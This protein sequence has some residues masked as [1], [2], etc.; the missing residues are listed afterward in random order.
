[1]LES[2]NRL[3]TIRESGTTKPP[4]CRIVAILSNVT[5]PN[6]L[7]LVPRLCPEPPTTVFLFCCLGPLLTN[8]LFS[9][10][11]TFSQTMFLSCPFFDEFLTHLLFYLGLLP[12]N[13]SFSPPPSHPVG[14]REAPLFPRTPLSIAFFACLCFFPRFS[15]PML[16]F[17]RYFPKSF[18]S[19]QFTTVSL[20]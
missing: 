16:P 5:R 3:V 17:L 10:I 2:V 9:F 1:M 20:P 18:M 13:E 8:V 12:G 19:P 6:P 15:K 7:F 11:S 14:T 4:R